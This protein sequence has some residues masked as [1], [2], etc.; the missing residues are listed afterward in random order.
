MTDEIEVPF[1]LYDNGVMDDYGLLG[2][3]FKS[4]VSEESLNGFRSY[5]KD[6]K[7]TLPDHSS[8][9]VG[10]AEAQLTL[11]HQDTPYS[12]NM[13]GPML[14]K[15][16]S[17]LDLL[18]TEFVGKTAWSLHSMWVNFYRAGN[19]QPLHK[20]RGGQLSYVWYLDVPEVIYEKVS[21][22]D[23][24]GEIHFC[25]PVLQDPFGLHIEKLK[26]ATGDLI[27]FDSRYMHVVYPF[28]ADVERI[29][30]AG[31]IHLH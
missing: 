10:T 7:N 31:N 11:T 30:A 18:L 13:Q 17:E 16:K 8:K 14:E 23:T 9:L 19:F 29:T 5:V 4:R 21:D 20:H 22:K 25:C 24:S 1:E 27:I 2:K 12:Q 15:F 6:S 26:P 28:T 3:I